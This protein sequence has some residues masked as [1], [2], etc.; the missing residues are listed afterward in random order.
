MLLRAQLR[1]KLN[2]KHYFGALEIQFGV[3]KAHYQAYLS[4]NG[5]GPIFVI[6]AIGNVAQG[7]IKENFKSKQVR[8][9]KVLRC[10]QQLCLLK[11]LTFLTLQQNRKQDH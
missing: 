10:S 4:K 11:I 7:T 3:K 1:N 6:Y 5:C 8:F 2:P 9:V